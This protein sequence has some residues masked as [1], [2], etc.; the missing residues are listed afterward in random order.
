MS[1]FSLNKYKNKSIKHMNNM[2]QYKCSVYYKIL[3]GIVHVLLSSVAIY[4][5]MQLNIK[6]TIISIIIALLL[7]Q[8]YIVYCVILNHTYVKY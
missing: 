5:S 7:P 4:Y 6:L 2:T 3:K 1:K 8:Y